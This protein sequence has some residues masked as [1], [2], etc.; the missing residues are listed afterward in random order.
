MNVTTKTRQSGNVTIV[1]LA[2]RVTLGASATALSD[3]IRALAAA[4]QKHLV[5]NLA[6]LQYID[7]SGVGELVASLTAVT[8]LGGSISLLNPI[9]RVRELLEIT[10]V[11]LL[12]KI[13]DNEPAA[14]S[15][16]SA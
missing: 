5:L 6:E 2:G 15:A 10:R 13:Y 1:D 11:N 12:F 3:Q 9:G 4:G 14:V 16:A 8:R 7:S